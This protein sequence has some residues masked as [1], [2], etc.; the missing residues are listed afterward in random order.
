MFRFSNFFTFIIT[1]QMIFW[2]VF[3]SK[4]NIS[5][6]SNSKI[7]WR[8]YEIFRVLTIKYTVEMGENSNNFSQKT[9]YIQNAYHLKTKC[10]PI[11]YTY[12]LLVESQKPHCQIWCEIWRA[13]TENCNM[14]R[15]PLLGGSPYSRL[16]ACA[17]EEKQGVYQTPRIGLHYVLL[18]TH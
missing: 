9:I 3:F 12:N 16:Y 18:L 2:I 13:K 6:V 4:K 5:N 10:N 15:S 1:P 11:Y 7:L 17:V 14:L 8:Y